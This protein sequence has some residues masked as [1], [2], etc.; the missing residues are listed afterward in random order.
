MIRRTAIRDRWSVPVFRHPAS[1]HLASRRSLA[2]GPFKGFESPCEVSVRLTLAA[3][4]RCPSAPTTS[5]DPA[6]RS[7]ACGVASPAPSLADCEPY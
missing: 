6:L 4:S 1:L 3:L 5:H 2:A 7:I